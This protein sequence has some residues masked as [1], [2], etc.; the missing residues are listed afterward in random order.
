MQ[1]TV[2]LSE[3]A[4]KTLEKVN[5][6]EQ[7]HIRRFIKDTLGNLDNPRSTG[8][9]LQ[10]N[11][12]DLWRYLVGDY[13]WSV[14]F[15]ITSLSLWCLKSDIEKRFINHE[16]LNFDTHEFVKKLKG[17]GFSE[18]QAEILTPQYLT[19]WNRCGMIMN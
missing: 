9:A 1:W 10:G 14:K 2:R 8:K 19:P 16:Y 11:L 6:P 17:V 7:L 13:R 3:T 18:E 12:K 15:I 5:K 4:L